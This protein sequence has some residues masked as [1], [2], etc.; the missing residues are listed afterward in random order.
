MVRAQRAERHQRQWEPIAQHQDHA[1]LGRAGTGEIQ[2]RSST[3]RQP[4][5][6]ALAIERGGLPFGDLILRRQYR[7]QALFAPDRHTMREDVARMA[8]VEIA[9]YRGMRGEVVAQI[10]RCTR[11]TQLRYAVGQ[12]MLVTVA[13]VARLHGS[14]DVLVAAEIIRLGE[15]R[16]RIELGRRFVGQ[17]VVQG[18]E[19]PAAGDGLGDRW[20]PAQIPDRIEIMRCD[21]VGAVFPQA[22][23]IVRIGTG[24]IGLLALRRIELRAVHRRI[25]QH[26][27]DA[28][29]AA[30]MLQEVIVAVDV[31]IGGQ[32]LVAQ[33]GI[34]QTI[35]RLLEQP[36]RRA[37]AETGAAVGVE[38]R[39]G[40][41]IA[42]RGRGAAK[43][44]QV[45]GFIEPEVRR[46]TA[47][48]T[49]L[50]IELQHRRIVGIA[51]SAHASGYAARYHPASNTAQAAVAC[52]GSFS[53]AR[54]GSS[55]I[56]DARSAA[57]RRAPAPRSHRPNSRA[58]PAPRRRPARTSA[59]AGACRPACGAA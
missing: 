38:P 23:E 44:P 7:G 28:P 17:I 12:E 58:A 18:A 50:Q 13:P 4:V 20:V 26:V 24:S 32:H 46:M 59:A 56:G 39:L 16:E 27:A 45:P 53:I 2:H 52:P 1:D 29:F 6:C 43:R 57:R 3:A 55:A 33:I 30:A 11:R 35:L 36:V 10:D 48:L 31:A 42:D 19:P 25:E 9:A 47:S 14:G 40:M 21:D 41:A 54:G 8:A 37:K 51:S 5:V 22:P 34:A 15:V 49:V